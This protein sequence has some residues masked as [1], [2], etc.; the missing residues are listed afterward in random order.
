MRAKNGFTLIELLMV[1]GVLGILLG[2]LIPS[3]GMVREKAQQL[4]TGQKLRQVA[5]AVATFHQVSGQT[6]VADSLGDWMLKLAEET[7]LRDARLFLMEEDP[8]VVGHGEPIPPALVERGS[9]G[10]WRLVGG[11]EDWPVG[12]VAVSGI[13]ALAPPSTTPVAWTRG[14]TKEG[15]WLDHGSRTSGIYGSQGG[16]VAFLD[17]HVAYYRDLGADGGK[18]LDYRTGQPTGDISRAIPPG[19]RAF[20]YMGGVF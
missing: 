4:A 2:M 20:D 11:F 9:D 16:F 8:L 13:P 10:R 18:L 3:V 1:L 19:A 15:R 12:V 6:L 7:G 14:L 5:L 17:G